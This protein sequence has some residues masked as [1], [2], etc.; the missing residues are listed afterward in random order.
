MAGVQHFTSATDA[1]L[2]TLGG[3]N[4][5]AQ[6]ANFYARQITSIAGRVPV[7]AIV[8]GGLHAGVIT[9]GTW[10]E[11]Q[12]TGLDVW[13]TVSFHDPDS[14]VGPATVIAA[15]RWRDYDNQQVISRRAVVSADTNLK[16]YGPNVRL[17]GSIGGL[18]PPVQ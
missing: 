5:D 3:I 10:H 14:T 4:Y 16:L 12:D 13:D 18:G 8:N 6:I 1:Y 17:R 2:D 7:L 11:D 9:G 15:G